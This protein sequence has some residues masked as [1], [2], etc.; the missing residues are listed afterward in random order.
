MKT[1]PEM[2]NK[3]EEGHC[4]GTWLTQSVETVTSD[5]RIVSSNPMLDVEIT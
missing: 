4:K 1:E 5:L 2:G 3:Q